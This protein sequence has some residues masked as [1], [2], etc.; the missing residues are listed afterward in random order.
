MK[1]TISHS[2]KYQ[3]PSKEVLPPNTRYAVAKDFRT[4]KNTFNCRYRKYYYWCR[5]NLKWM[6]WYTFPYD[7]KEDMQNQIDRLRMQVKNNELLV[8]V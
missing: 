1:K 7:D 8:D 6:R 3:R 5:G 4:S 2:K